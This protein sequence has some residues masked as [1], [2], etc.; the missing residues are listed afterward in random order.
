MPTTGVIVTGGAS[1]I[2]RASAEALAAAGRPV[3][4]W[5]LDEAKATSVAAEITVAYGVAA[6]GFGLDVREHDRFAAA[7][8]ASREA[9]GP[10]G[11]LIHAAGVTGVGPIDQF[12]TATWEATLAIH[13]TAAAVLLRELTPDFVANPGSAAVLISSIEGI[14][15]HGA[16]PAYCS[17]KA[18][19]LGLARSAGA[20]LATRG[21]R[22]NAICPGFIETPMLAPAMA[23]P[24]TQTAYE[25]RIPLGRLG[26][27]EEIGKVARFLLS[28]DAS[29]ITSAEFVVDGGVSKTTF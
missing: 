10:I 29:Y 20:H 25:Q 22:V 8:H 2:G 18:G 9:I 7:I 28:D 23:M 12:E 17:A 16:I 6:F 5:D 3:A 14:V 27:P 26:Q 15:S 11:G 19:L 1:G 4:L 24:G 21:V 13:L